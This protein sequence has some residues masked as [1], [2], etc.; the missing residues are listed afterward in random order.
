MGR[1]RRTDSNSSPARGRCSNSCTCDRNVHIVYIAA[2]HTAG[3]W[4]KCRRCC[5]RNHADGDSRCSPNSANRKASNRIG[6]S[7]SRGRNSG[8][9]IDRRHSHCRRGN[10]LPC[11]RHGYTSRDHSL[12]RNHL[13]AGHCLGSPYDT[14]GH[15]RQTHPHKNRRKSADRIEDSSLDN[16]RTTTPLARAREVR[17]SS[18]PPNDLSP[19]GAREESKIART[20]SGRYIWYRRHNR[21]NPTNW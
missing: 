11:C 10:S 12:Q 6:R 5:L 2:G 21:Q 16:Q 19:H 14:A 18:F 3:R 1:R 8:L 7:D 4:H 9:C 13:A 20:R 15:T 17:F